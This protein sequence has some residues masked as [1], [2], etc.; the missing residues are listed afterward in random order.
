MTKM[1]EFELLSEASNVI[2]AR[3]K[4]RNFPGILVQG[5]TLKTLLDDIEEL[6]EESIA[7]N[8]ET[9]IEISKTL[10]GK[11]IELLTHYERVLGEHEYK[12]PYESSVLS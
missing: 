6:H 11:L 4:E 10:R 7:G 12:L 2:V 8:L 5:D 9:T 1:R 3:H